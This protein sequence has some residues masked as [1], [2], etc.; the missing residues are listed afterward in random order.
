MKPISTSLTLTTS[1]RWRHAAAMLGRALGKPVTI[2]ARGTDINYI[3]RYRL[4][5][6]QI[7]SV[8]REAS[9]LIAVSQALKTEMAALGIPPDRITVLRNG[10]DLQTF[11]PGDRATARR[12]LGLTG[13]TLLSV[14]HLIPRKGHDLIISALFRLEGYTL[15]IAGEGPEKPALHALAQKLGVAARVRFLGSLPHS[16]LPRIYSA[17][18]ALVLASSR[19]GWPNV[20]LEA[21]ACGTPV[22]ASPIWATEGG[23]PP[24]G[25]RSDDRSNCQR[26][27]PGRRS[28]VPSIADTRVHPA[29]RR[30]L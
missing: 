17:A 19:E 12:E 23:K 2:T 15:L 11:H 6:K 24:R 26:G 7:L 1:I 27:S 16:D 3:P 30:S 5:R 4:P 25:W 13:R 21:M 20:L 9:G 8:A 18:D 29:F 10:V 14:G 22:V 28:L